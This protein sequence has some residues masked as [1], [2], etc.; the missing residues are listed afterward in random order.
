M[1]DRRGR[2]K[3]ISDEDL[4]NLIKRYGEISQRKLEELT[5]MKKS[6]LSMIIKHF[7][8]Q[9]KIKV[10]NVREGRSTLSLVS[11][12]TF[13][14]SHTLVKPILRSEKE[15]EEKYR[16]LGFIS[17]L[18]DPSYLR[19]VLINWGFDEEI[20][21]LLDDSTVAGLA[22]VHVADLIKEGIPSEIATEILDVVEEIRKEFTK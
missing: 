9:G 16:A 22:N 4:L 17:R 14:Q 10:R 1:V 3:I 18:T 2:P 20:V 7:H 8:K 21:D 6:T 11:F 5:G 15:E 12:A 13:D 19:K